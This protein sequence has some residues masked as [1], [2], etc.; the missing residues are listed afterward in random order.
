[1]RARQTICAHKIQLQIFK[2]PPHLRVSTMKCK[3]RCVRV[4]IHAFVYTYRFC[5]FCHYHYSCFPICI[6]IYIYACHSLFAH[7]VSEAKDGYEPL[8]K[9][10]EIPP[11]KCPKEPYPKI[12]SSDSL[13]KHK[14]ALKAWMPLSPVGGFAAGCAPKPE[15]PGTRKQT[16]AKELPRKTFP[17]TLLE[18]HPRRYSPNIRLN[19]CPK[20]DFS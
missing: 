1:M 10:L 11:E 9:F 7:A 2:V 12:N 4:H 16:C 20:A 14:L 6:Y 15:R 3:S 17:T 18:R 19:T 8:C 5:C 13:T